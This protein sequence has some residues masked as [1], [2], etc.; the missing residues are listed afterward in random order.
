MSN[1]VLAV[2]VS[3]NPKLDSLAASIKPL[4]LAHCDVLVVDNASSNQSQIKQCCETISAARVKDDGENSQLELLAL[5]RNVGLGAAHNKGI[6]KARAGSFDYLLFLDQD[7]ILSE[8]CLATLLNAHQAKIESGQKVSAV[9]ASY[10]H[11]TQKE[12]VYI[13]FGALKFSR[14]GAGEQDSQGCVATDFLISSG[15]LISTQALDQIGSM[16]ETLFIDHV[17][18]E[19]FLRARAKGYQAF[20]VPAAKMEHGLGEVT[21]VVNLSGRQRNVPQHKPFRY[22]YIF[23]NSVLLYRRRYIS[24]LWKWNDLQRLFLIFIMFGIATAPRW[25]NIS[26]MCKGISHG[27]LGRTGPLKD[28]YDEHSSAAEESE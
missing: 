24:A 14:H 20:G 9:G 1:R 28:S 23:R 4:L 22:Y 25:Q 15:S 26:M 16:D 7:T 5:Q 6:N 21:H 10:A 12:S 13:R 8:N 17:D 18:T 3:Y 2:I 19:W 11:G 27:V